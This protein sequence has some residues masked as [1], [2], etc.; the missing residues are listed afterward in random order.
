MTYRRRPTNYYV[1]IMASPSRVLYTGVTNDL[2]RRVSEHKSEIGSQFVARYHATE[3]VYVENFA[4]IRA[5]IEREKQ[6]KG[7]MRKKKISLV[8]TQNREWKDLRVAEQN[9]DSSLRSE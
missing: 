3:L 6:I 4:D 1:Y 7:L 2:D 9:R 8:E 5:A